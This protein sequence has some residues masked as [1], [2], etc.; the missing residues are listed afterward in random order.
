MSRGH[1]VGPGLIIIHQTRPSAQ[2]R[3]PSGL[4]QVRGNHYMLTSL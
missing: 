2:A 3:D 4:L 1:F